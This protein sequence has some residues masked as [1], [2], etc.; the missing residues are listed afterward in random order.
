M[1]DQEI[2]EMS[3]LWRALRGFLTAS[4]VAG[5]IIG[6]AIFVVTSD[7]DIAWPLG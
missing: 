7:V 6:I 4:S 2:E 1:L 5:C 3:P